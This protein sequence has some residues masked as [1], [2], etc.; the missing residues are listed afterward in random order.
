MKEPTRAPFYACLY[1]GL[2]DIARAHGYALAI[3][4]TVT[5][6]LDLIAVPWTTAAVPAEELM[7]TLME[8]IGAVDYHGLLQRQLPTTPPEQIE[9]L[10][11]AEYAR[12]SDQHG[13][14]GA[15]QKPHGRKAWNLY[16]E[17][18]AKVDLSIMPREEMP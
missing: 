4:G 18:G 16:L 2:C 10:V 15:A 13:P 17:Y 5:K 9:K 8:H 11:A 1:P 14:D 6:D 12:Q 7:R 3:H